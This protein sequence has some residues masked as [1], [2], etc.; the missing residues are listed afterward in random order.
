MVWDSGRKS[1]GRKDGMVI[2]VPISI[3]AYRKSIAG[4]SIVIMSPCS[5]KPDEPQE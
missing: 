4:D 3:T 1:V 5:S 2:V